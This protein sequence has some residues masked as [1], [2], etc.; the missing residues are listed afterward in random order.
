MRHINNPVFPNMPGQPF[1][2]MPTSD[3]N[4]MERQQFPMV[5][6]IDPAAPFRGGMQNDAM[7]VQ[8]DELVNQGA[9]TQDPGYL[10]MMNQFQAPQMNTAKFDPRG[11]LMGGA[12]M[13][14]S[15]IILGNNP[16]NNPMKAYQMGRQMYMQDRSLENQQKQRAFQNQI[17]VGG[18]MA[19]LAKD[20][21]PNDIR[22]MKAY[23]LDP[24]NPDDVEKFYVI[25]NQGKGTNINVDASQKGNVELSEQRAK[26]AAKYEAELDSIVAGAPQTQ[27]I[28]SQLEILNAGIDTA[29]AVGNLADGIN[30]ALRSVGSSLTVTG[31][32]QWREAYRGLSN[33]LALNELQ[34][35]KG[36]TTD[37]EFGVAASINGNLD[38]TPEGREILL[39]L[40]QSRSRMNQ[41]GAQAY[42][43]WAY[44]YDGIPSAGKFT[45]SDA[46]KQLQLKTMYSENPGSLGKIIGALD[47]DAGDKFYK[48]RKT[49][50]TKRYKAAYPDEDDAKILQMVNQHMDLELGN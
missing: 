4:V 9:L 7:T 27:D 43:D 39:M 35:F 20:S 41:V 38:Q 29:G 13:D 32:T 47:K 24:M 18:L 40:A 50:M 34:F 14:L 44:G 26:N 1:M 6:D 2:Q 30:R 21:S 37:F 5:T 10:S 25:R 16:S 33:K 23:G 8:I 15:E 42:L 36:P 11:A 28:I 3:M 46:Y 12:L 17:A 45:K 19:T 22:L 48:Q 31:D 49:E